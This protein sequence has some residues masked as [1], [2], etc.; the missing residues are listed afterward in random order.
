M[1]IIHI[2]IS[3][4]MNTY[5]LINYIIPLYCGNALYPYPQNVY[6]ITSAARLLLPFKCE[7]LSFCVVCKFIQPQDLSKPH[8][9][10]H[11]THTHIH[12]HHTWTVSLYSIC[13]YMESLLVYLRMLMVYI[14]VCDCDR[15]SHATTSIE[16]VLACLLSSLFSETRSEER[17]GGL[18]DILKEPRT[19]TVSQKHSV[20]QC[21]A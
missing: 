20:P 13:Y 16:L 3:S 2:H 1:Q 4:R 12:T 5:D 21:I 10:T 8:F 17:H 6:I 18:N 9:T 14:G 19:S 15:A 11:R 7:Y